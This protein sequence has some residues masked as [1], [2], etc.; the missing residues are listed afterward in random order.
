MRTSLVIGLL[1]FSPTTESTP[2]WL[3]VELLWPG[4]WGVVRGAE[5]LGTLPA[6]IS[7]RRESHP[8]VAFPTGAPPEGGAP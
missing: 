8:R 6:R 3:V 1:H 5:R 7:T 4:Y 2:Q